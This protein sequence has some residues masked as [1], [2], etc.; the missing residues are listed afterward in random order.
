MGC[1]LCQGWGKVK[2]HGA[3]VTEASA[4]ARELCAG[5]EMNTS[6]A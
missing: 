1:T 3:M 2:K 4:D 5:V 6:Q